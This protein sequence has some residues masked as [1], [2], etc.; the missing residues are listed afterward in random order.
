M[1]NKNNQK[2]DRKDI[3]LS[4]RNEA[5]KDLIKAIKD[6]PITFVVGPAGCGKSH[7]PSVFALQQ[8]LKGNYRKIIFTRPCVEA[9]GENLGFLPG[10]YNDKIAPYMMPIFDILEQVL[11]K[12]EIDRLFKDGLIQTIP[13]AFQRGITFQNSFVLADEFQNTIPAQMRMFLTR[14]GDNCKMVIT[15]DLSQNDIQGKNGLEDAIQRFDNIEQIKIIKMEHK[16]IVRNPL[17]E[18]IDKKYLE[19]A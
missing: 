10:D 5:Q 7:I 11:P 8:L 13:L 19:N 2:N 18:I 4:A 9:Y 3:V 1:A 14:M 6:Y 17:V 12:P 15:G 16:D